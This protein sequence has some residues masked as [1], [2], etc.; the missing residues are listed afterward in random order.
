LWSFKTLN[1]LQVNG[2][3]F[4]RIAKNKDLVADILPPPAYIIKLHLTVVQLSAQVRLK[5]DSA[6][7]ANQLAR[8]VYQMAFQGGVVESIQHVSDKV[9][10]IA[11]ASAEQSLGVKQV[12]DA[13]AQMDQ[14]TQ[15]NAALVEE[16]A[17]AAKGLKQQAGE[18]VSQ[19]A[20]FRLAPKGSAQLRTMMPA[21]IAA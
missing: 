20:A 21:L 17:N 3:L 5:T 14:V 8:N 6:R 11:S 19:V 12:S 16:M 13:V 2:P 7:E 15:Q 9:G 10:T 1:E 18:L 4:Q